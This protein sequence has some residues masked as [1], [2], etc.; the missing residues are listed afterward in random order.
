MSGTTVIV[1]VAVASAHTLFPITVYVAE[2][3]GVAITE[4]PVL[5]LNPADGTHE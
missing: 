4:F 5:E 3:V 1:V 2:I